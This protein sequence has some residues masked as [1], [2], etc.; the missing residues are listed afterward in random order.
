LEG[1]CAVKIPSGEPLG[2][3]RVRE[4]GGGNC[5]SEKRKKEAK[6]LEKLPA[7]QRDRKRSFDKLEMMGRR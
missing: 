1:S 6:P 2:D 7:G 5:P 4:G 3:M